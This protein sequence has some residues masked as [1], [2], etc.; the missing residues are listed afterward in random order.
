M[1]LSLRQQRL[2]AASSDLVGAAHGIEAAADLLGKGKSTIGRYVN[3]NDEDYWMPVDAV[4]ALERVTHGTPGHPQVTAELCRLAGGVFV[5]LPAAAGGDGELRA[6]VMHLSSE[7][8][9]VAREIDGA[10]RDNKV[11]VSEETAIHRQIDDL[12]AKAV[13]LKQA[14][15][16]IVDRDRGRTVRK[17]ER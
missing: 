4:A 8:G 16:L 15:T 11:C 5:P 14:V 3:I 9:D 7:L 13:E 17:G 2:K 1:T 12:I 10:L 6:G